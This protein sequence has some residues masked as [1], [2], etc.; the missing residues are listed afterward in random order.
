MS[1]TQPLRPLKGAEVQPALAQRKRTEIGLS[2]NELLYKGGKGGVDNKREEKKPVGSIN[3]HNS[4][5]LHELIEDSANQ[6]FFDTTEHTK[7][8]PSTDINPDEEEDQL[9]IQERRK[10]IHQEK[11]ERFERDSLRRELRTKQQNTRS[12]DLLE[13]LMDERETFVGTL[14]NYMDRVDVEAENRKQK[15]HQQWESSVFKP[16]QDVVKQTMDSEFELTKEMRRDEYEKFLS[17]GNRRNVYLETINPVEYDPLATTGSRLKAKVAVADPLK[18]ERHTLEYETK[19][20][21]K[22]QGRPSSTNSANSSDSSPMLTRDPKL[23]AK[24]EE[25][26]KGHP[27]TNKRNASS[28]Q[29]KD[30]GPSQSTPDPLPPFRPSKK[31][32]QTR[33]KEGNGDILAFNPT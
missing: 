13:E 18:M 2:T 21:K 12:V 11:M 31:P 32:V 14:N 33:L 15:Q 6:Q 24:F 22:I 27:E 4:N 17:Y 7:S 1:A 30:L 25:M 5:I 20:A 28:F 3:V 9:R 19:L 8:H 23:I 10:L 16:I 29:F 26:P